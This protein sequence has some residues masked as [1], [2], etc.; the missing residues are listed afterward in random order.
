MDVRRE[1][2]VPERIGVLGL[3]VSLV[4]AG[5]PWVAA[6]TDLGVPCPTRWL[7]GVPCPACGLTTAAVA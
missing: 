1:F 2:S 4:A 3:G 7:T 6:T 5:W